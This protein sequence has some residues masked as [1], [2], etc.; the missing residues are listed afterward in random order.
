[1]YAS[2][3]D[4]Y[5]VNVALGKTATQSISVAAMSEP[6]RAV[7]GSIATGYDARAGYADVAYVDIAHVTLQQPAKNWWAVRL[8]KSLYIG[9]ILLYGSVAS[10]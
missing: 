3:S 6:Y 7:D 1:M 10:K 2:F 5:P 9:Y 8:S 4:G